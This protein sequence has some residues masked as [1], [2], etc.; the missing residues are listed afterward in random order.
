K[1]KQKPKKGVYGGRFRACYKKKGQK[2]L[3][4]WYEGGR[5]YKIKEE[6]KKKKKNRGE[7]FLAQKKKKKKLF[8]FFYL[9]F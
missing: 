4:L 6:K 8:F 5:L 1:K 7:N 9:F 2:I 3:N